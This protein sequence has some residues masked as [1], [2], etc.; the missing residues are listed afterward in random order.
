MKVAI[1][2]MSCDNTLD[3]LTHFIVGFK[4]YWG[5]CPFDIYIGSN[6][7]N[8]KLNF[9]NYKILPANKSNWKT[10][11]LEQ[12]EIIRKLDSDLTHLIV[13]LD[14]FIL[15]NPVSNG[16][17]FEICNYKELDSIKYLRL[18]RLE[19]GLFQ[20]CIQLFQNKIHINKEL[21]FKIRKVHPYFSSLQVSL[22]NLE[23]LT[24]TLNQ[25]TDIWDFETKKY[26]SLDHYSVTE[27]IIKYKHIVQKG[28]WEIYS[29]KY[30]ENK[31]GYFN[32]GNRLL[33]PNKSINYLS[34]YF[35]KAKFFLLGYFYVN[36]KTHVIK[37]NKSSNIF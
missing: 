6:N 23:H 8:L 5:D 29:K 37:L 21:I 19:D 31:I 34:Y 24:D 12:L 28:K 30:C 7:K 10:E 15:S 20:K 33:K 18:K 36:L 16:R 9:A 14:D 4:K 22:W 11:T 17:I 13:F 26:E 3:V 35:L 25:A 1:Y 2:I 32:Q 27:T